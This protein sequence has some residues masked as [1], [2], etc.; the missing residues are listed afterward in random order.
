MTNK[1]LQWEQREI[2]NVANKIIVNEINQII[3]FKRRLLQVYNNFVQFCI[4]LIFNMINILLICSMIHYGRLNSRYFSLYAIS[5]PT[6]RTWLYKW[7]HELM[8]KSQVDM[9]SHRHT[10]TWTHSQIMRFLHF[11]A[12]RYSYKLQSCFS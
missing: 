8:F 2:P 9:L 7:G 12:S 6:T 1:I 10:N 3:N 4:R 5:W 11:Y